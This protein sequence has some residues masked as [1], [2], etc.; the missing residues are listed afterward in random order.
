MHR[1]WSLIGFC[2][3]VDDVVK[4][5]QLPCFSHMHPNHWTGKSEVAV[6]CNPWFFT[7]SKQMNTIWS[8]TYKDNWQTIRRI[9]KSFINEVYRV[10]SPC[11][12]LLEVWSVPYEHQSPWQ[13]KRIPTKCHL[14]CHAH[15]DKHH[16]SL[17]QEAWEC[18][19]QLLP[20]LHCDG[21][22]SLLPSLFE[23]LDKA[24]SLYWGRLHT[25]TQYLNYGE[26]E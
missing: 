11:L 8:N 1:N 16:W 20:L 21:E 23:F 24:C 17:L 13:F 6:F 15:L 10:Q 4:V 19:Q 9:F 5:C 7:N 2:C 22:I 18:N 3:V 14:L 25:W 12:L 26:E